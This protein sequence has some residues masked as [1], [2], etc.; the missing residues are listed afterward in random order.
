MAIRTY[1]IHDNRGRPFR[2]T[3][4]EGSDSAPSNTV[5]LYRLIG[6]LWDN[7]P[8]EAQY[9]SEPLRTWN[10]TRVMLGLSTGEDMEYTD[11]SGPE[12]LGNTILL[13]LNPHHYVFIGSA[14]Y[15]F[16]TDDVIMRFSSPIGGNDVP[17]P[18]ARGTHYSYLFAHYLN[19][20]ER[21]LNVHIPAGDLTAEPEH[22]REHDRRCK[23]EEFVSK[24]TRVQGIVLQERL[25][26]WISS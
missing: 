4:E 2:V 12:T 19:G 21:I 15:A 8:A 6:G 25:P 14:V 23:G 13:E 24:F 22:L 17:Y 1:H 7:E 10:P 16:D 18:Y 26:H 9:E 5:K 3:V 20:A 11:W